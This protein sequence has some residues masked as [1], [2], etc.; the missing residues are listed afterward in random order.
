MAGIRY[1]VS[2]AIR[3]WYSSRNV[4]GRTDVAEQAEKSRG[5][6]LKFRLR[7][8]SFTRPLPQRSPV[9]DLSKFESSAEPDDYRHRMV[10]NLAGLAAAVVLIL[11]GI[12]IVSTMAQMR[13]N[14]DCVLQ[15]RRDCATIKTQIIPRPDF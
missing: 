3:L 9:E 1:R 4:T 8:S 12:W 5:Q 6:I 15:G 7:G 14:Q 2:A 11:V 10:T 13:K